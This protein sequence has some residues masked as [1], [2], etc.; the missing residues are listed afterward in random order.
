M[1]LQGICVAPDD[2]TLEGSPTW[3][4][5]DGTYQVTDWHI[6]RGRQYELDT[7]GTGTASISLVDT[8]GDFDPTNGG[9]TFGADR[10]LVMRQAAINVQNP[11]DSSYNTLFRGFVSSVTYAPYVSETMANVTLDLVDGLAVLGAAE[12][13]S[14]GTFGTTAVNGNI[15]FAGDTALTAVQTRINNVLDQLGWPSGMRSIFT[16]NV[17]LQNAIYAPRTPVLTVIQDA[18][19]AEWPNVANFYMS[20]GGLATF[21]GRLARFDPTNPDYGITTWYLGDYAAAHASPST[22]VP[23]S[24]PLEIVMDD[25]NLFT[26]ATA[27]P[28]GVADSAISGQY[29]TAPASIAAY[30][31]R[32]WSAENLLTNG[33]SGTSALVETLKF[34]THIVTN[35]A[36]PRIRVGQVTVRPQAPAGEF[37]TATWAMLMGVDI[38]DVVQITTTQAGGG[39]FF[40][41]Q[42]FVEGVHY[43]AV[44]MNPT[45][46]EITLALDVSP[47]SYYATNVF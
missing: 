43:D 46:P 2:A 7:T 38:S 8:T 10:P 3:T 36:A 26:A 32:T 44:P 42:F 40:S 30:G 9:G 1:T 16:G 28:Q 15:Q 25:Q 6:D 47:T 35:Y 45:N 22:V 39:G 12:M 33:G 29:T 11:T 24:P 14:D 4:R 5:L 23:I 31:T 37:G 34:A 21:H 18:A 20:R 17:K 27:T 13:T 41:N 19:D